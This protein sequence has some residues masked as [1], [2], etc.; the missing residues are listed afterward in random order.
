MPSP[1]SG[2]RWVCWWS[3]SPFTAAKAGW[4][5]ARKIG[6]VFAPGQAYFLL[7]FLDFFYIVLQMFQT[8][9][10][11]FA[12]S[13][14]RGLFLRALC[15]AAPPGGHGGRGVQNPE[16]DCFVARRTT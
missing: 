9:P 14:P 16:N 15:S 7:V 2:W 11:F 10:A 4:G 12:F 3:I 1:G 6:R 13:G 5:C 8:F